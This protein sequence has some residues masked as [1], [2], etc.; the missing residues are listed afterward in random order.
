SFSKVMSRPS[1]SMR[2]VSVKKLPA[3]AL[4]RVDLPAPLEPTMAAKSPAS[5][6]RS[7][8]RSAFFSFSV[9]GLKVLVM[10]VRVSI[11]ARLLSLGGQFSPH[12]LD[13]GS[14]GGPADGHRHDDGADELEVGGVG[15]GAQSAHHQH[16]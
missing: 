11:S 10:L 4:N 15:A 6:C 7:M 8:P 14:E 12:K 5:R 9:P 3:M 13:P 1:S 2:P 16:T